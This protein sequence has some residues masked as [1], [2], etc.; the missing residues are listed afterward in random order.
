MSLLA[1]SSLASK[2]NSDDGK[3]SVSSPLPNELLLLLLLVLLFMTC[4]VGSDSDV[5][6][7]MS[8]CT[9][10]AVS[11]LIQCFSSFN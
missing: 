6:K 1:A 9:L 4:V 11:E 2:L 8:L 10:N 3:F 7:V 5:L